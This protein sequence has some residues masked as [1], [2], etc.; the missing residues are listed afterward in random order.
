[1]PDAVSKGWAP[2]LGPGRLLVLLDAAKACS[3]SPPDLTALGKPHFTALSY[4]KIFGWV[5]YKDESKVPD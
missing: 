1:V 5:N 4:Y 3:S 2:D